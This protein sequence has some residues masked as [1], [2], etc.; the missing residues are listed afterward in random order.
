MAKIEFWCFCPLIFVELL[1]L[2]TEK[3]RTNHSIIPV[4]RSVSHQHSQL[5]LTTCSN[6]ST[7][8]HFWDVAPF[9]EDQ[10]PIT[11][12]SLSLLTESCCLIYVVAKLYAIIH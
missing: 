12:A 10:V 7:R 11:V 6:D 3:E 4:F 1:I 5:D 2:L 8:S 9:N